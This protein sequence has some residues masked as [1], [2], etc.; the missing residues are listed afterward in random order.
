MADETPDARLRAI[1][2]N[3]GYRLVK[4]RKRKPERRDFGKYGLTDLQGKPVFGFGKNWLTASA[5]QVLE[6]LRQGELKL[7]KQSAATTRRRPKPD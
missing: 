5:A 1:A 6:Y 3:R 2:K 4:S 7:W